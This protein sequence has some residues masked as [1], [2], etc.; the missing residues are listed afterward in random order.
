V[1][2]LGAVTQSHRTRHRHMQLYGC[3]EILSRPLADVSQHTMI[4]APP[5]PVADTS[6]DDDVTLS[7][8][9]SHSEQQDPDFDPMALQHSEVNPTDSETE[10]DYDDNVG[11]LDSSNDER[12][13]HDDIESCLSDVSHMHSSNVEQADPNFE[14]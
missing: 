14:G 1:K 4:E 8:H 2:C 7:N 10:D 3:R 5:S 12:P 6:R 13:I 9:L 11:D